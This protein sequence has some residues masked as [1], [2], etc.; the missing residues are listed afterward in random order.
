MIEIQ[1]WIA[2][3]NG[4]Q[5][6]L[7]ATEGNRL[8]ASVDGYCYGLDFELHQLWKRDNPS[9]GTGISTLATTKP[10]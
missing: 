9:T 2:P 1:T 3:N 8:V 6:A 5:V 4:V 7:I 10:L